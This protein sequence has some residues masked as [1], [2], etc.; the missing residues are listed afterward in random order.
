MGHDIQDIKKYLE[1]I[2]YTS[3]ISNDSSTLSELCQHH[4]EYNPFENLDMFGG[5][6]KRLDFD[7]VYNDIIVKKR[8]GCCYEQNGLFYWALRKCGYEVTIVQCEAFISEEKGYGPSFD[9][10]AL[11]V[12]CD[13]GSVWLTDV[14]WGGTGFITLLKFESDKEQI[15]NNGVYR[16][17]GSTQQRFLLQK[18]QK[19]IIQVNGSTKIKV[20]GKQWNSIYRFDI[21]PR[22]WEDFK[23]MCEYQQDD[24]DSYLIHNT[25]CA[26]Q[27]K[28]GSVAVR[29]WM[30]FEKMFVD[31][32]TE[33]YKWRKETKSQEEL[34]EVLKKYFQVEINFDLKPEAKFEAD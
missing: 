22:K 18:L 26:K 7:K 3:R 25:I 11:L 6:R 29:G 20:K 1:R 28:Y 12:T 32:M 15:Q 9:H 2:N 34:K 27:S 30:T 24:E 13:D 10:M 8:G 4:T 23:E 17:L 19:T 14:G 33:K 16:L 31:P 21:I 5:E